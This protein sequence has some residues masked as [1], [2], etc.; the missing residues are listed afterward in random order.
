[1]SQPKKAVKQSSISQFFRRSS[2]E[3][4][5]DDVIVVDDVAKLDVIDLDPEP[6]A[7]N[8]IPTLKPKDFPAVDTRSAEESTILDTPRITKQPSTKTTNAKTTIKVSKDKP[9]PKRP[10]RKNPPA[11][12]KKALTPLE[13]QILQLKESNTDK[14]LLVQIGYKYKLFG[15]D[16]QL[17]SAILNIMY[18]QGEDEKFAYCSFPDFKLHINLKRILAHGHKVGVVKQ[19]ESSIVKSVE[20]VGASDVM[21]RELTAIYT[22]GTYMSDEIEEYNSNGLTEESSDYIIGIHENG[23]KFSLVA[24][25]PVTGEIINDTFVDTA[26]LE[27]RLLYLNPSEVI[28]VN[29]KESVSVQTLQIL[30]FI[31]PEVLIIH[32]L[33]A[34]SLTVSSELK[35]FFAGVDSLGKYVHLGDYFITNF[36]E[37]IQVCVLELISYL[38]EFKLSTIFTIPENIKPFSN[39]LKHMILPSNTLYALEIFKNFT[40]PTSSKGSL[41]WLLDH[42]RTRFGKRA[43]IQWISK[44]LIERDMIE[45]RH[46]AIEDM[47]TGFIQVVDIYKT[48]L[49]KIGRN[50]DLEELLIKTH[51]SACY[52]TSKISRRE[53]YLMLDYFTEVV[54]LTRKF[55]QAINILKL[56]SP[57]LISLFK[58]LQEL[59]ESDV[60][61]NFKSLINLSYVLNEYKEPDDLKTHFFNLN[62]RN[63][64]EI[65]SQF[66]K[67]SEL[68]GKLDGELEVIRKLLNRPLLNY[69]TNNKEPFLIEV[70]NGKQVNDLP[71]NFHRISGTTTV[72]RFRTLE[73]IRL[74]KL[75]QYH[76]EMLLLSCD[77]AFNQFLCEIDENYIYFTKIIKT[78]STLDCLLSLTA[79]SGISK[80]VKPQLVDERIIEVIHGRN[81]IIENLLHIVSYVPNDIDFRY[82]EK[83]VLIITGPN[84]GGK[85]SYVK[86]VAL[87]VV[88]SQIGC[89]I[90]CE[91]AKLGVF[92]LVFIRMGAQ[93]DI[94]KGNSTF[95]TEMLECSTIINNITDKSL[96]ILDEIGRGTG[97]SDGIAIAHL[98]LSYLIELKLSPIVLFITH[99]SSLHVL[100][101][102]Y[103]KKVM[104]YHMGFEQVYKKEQ[105]F[106]EIIF[107]YNLVEGVVN[108]LYGLNVAKLADIPNSII[109]KAFEISEAL[110]GDIES[111]SSYLFAKKLFGVFQELQEDKLQMI[112]ELMAE[113]A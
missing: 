80:T 35:N 54:Q 85:S 25:Q 98:I 113:H 7:A 75:I 8:N 71:A 95:M 13:K 82:D 9:A 23:N 28:V 81:P 76:K 3:K 6:V 43:L 41:I 73:T 88:M 52:K 87:L 11:I 17:G 108:N 32:K 92:D 38:A 111:R 96:V 109:T 97:T 27:T 102:L 66:N 112:E 106:P 12:K 16:A 110:K 56:K 48:F 34:D 90:P 36:N 37:K 105:Q 104:N 14:L 64:D 62:Y 42:T 59:S 39:S 46:Q 51:Y 78:L 18:I 15:K 103:P 47:S 84:M 44:P 107:K 67:I 30:K 91:S 89:F 101:D 74:Y 45:Q 24:T 61:S 77:E 83:R 49:D 33:E 10:A 72:S 31:N 60:A 22:K 50:V 57:L 69:V 55:D 26:E 93:D 79:A 58:D 100:Q 29:K 19:M 63:W 20:K 99:Y 70:R 1:M 53:V 21:R 86:Q 40:D 65:S 68:E 4:V 2:Q 5:K 94:L